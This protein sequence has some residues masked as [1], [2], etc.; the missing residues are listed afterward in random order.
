MNNDGCQYC[1]R[2]GLPLL[3]LRIAY[4]PKGAQT[5]PA[6]MGGSQVPEAFQDGGNTLRV[7]TDG[8]VY[9]LDMR[10]GGFWRCFAATPSGHFREY[11][12]DTP[13][14]S[15]PTFACSLSGHNLDASLVSIERAS[16]A[17]EVW[18]AYSRAWWTPATRRKL[19]T[20]AALRDRL[21][22]KVGAASMVKGG[23]VPTVIG[24]RVATGRDLTTI[25]PEYAIDDASFNVVDKRYATNTVDPASA[26][27]GQA[28][29]LIKRMQ[30]ISPNNAIVL[31]LPD[32]VGMA[33]DANHWRNLQAGELVNLQAETKQ[34]RS[35]LVGDLILGLEKSMVD[36][37]QSEEWA[38]RY[39][40]HV[41]MGRVRQDKNAFDTA[42]ERIEKKVL[43]ASDDWLAVV[44]HA[45]FPDAWKVY[46]PDSAYCGLQMEADFADCVFGSGATRKEQDW[47]DPWL[48]AKPDDEQH[49]VWLAFAAGDK[50]VIKYL[51]GDPSKPGETGK[52]SKGVSIG[53]HGKAIYDEFG[54]WQ[55]ARREKNLVRSAQEASGMLGM[56][57]ATQLARVATTQPKAAEQAIS[58][59]RVIASSRMDVLV[60]RYRTQISLTE[61][62]VQLHETVWGQPKA[63]LSATV[64]EARRLKIAQSIDGAFLGGRFTAERVVTLD[65]WLPEPVIDKMNQA[66]NAVIPKG[67]GAPAPRLALG[68]PAL[69]PWQG[70]V[71]YAKSLKGV[72]G[73]LFGLGA[74]LTICN[75]NWVFVQAQRALGSSA[76]TD[77]QLK[78][79]IAG[80][81]SGGMG[82]ASL[83][84][85]IFAGVV[86]GRAGRGVTT[87][88]ANRLILNSVKLKLG[89][90]LLG[91][92]MGVTEAYLF[93]GKMTTAG[94]A[95][96]TDAKN[97]Y[98]DATFFAAGAGFLSIPIAIIGAAQT[99][100]AI[101][102]T[103]AFA[104]A[105]TGAAGVLS[106]IPL[107]G[108]II[109][110][111]GAIAASVYFAYKAAKAEDTPLEIWLSRCYYRD[112]ARYA[113]TSREKFTQ[114]KPEMADFQ[115]AVYGLTVTL[116]W[117]DRIGKDRIDVE[118]IM[119]GYAGARSE[120][121]FLFD[122]RQAGS[123][124]MVID[125]KSSAFS[126]DS[127][128]KPQPAA[129]HF[130]SAASPNSI[131]LDRVVE[132]EQPTRLEVIGATAR[133]VAQVYA[134]EDYFDTARLKF[135][136]WP[137][138][139]GH[140]DLVMTPVPG[141]AN[142]QEVRD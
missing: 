21:M 8:Y 121:A 15:V 92:L 69:N 97:A 114:L 100:S 106:F 4:V 132:V 10:A 133:L 142:M 85:E 140:P 41:D 125:R 22:I 12:A 62:I 64:R 131:P 93:W 25:A 43:K 104:S 24:A 63:G 70:T 113:N 139:V 26:R 51:T 137:D 76:A 47:W 53:K 28:D 48:L 57:L 128:L 81:V 5:I 129:Q 2:L 77:P 134:N 135:E 27:V 71:N 19:K 45:N 118:V 88:V 30:A 112:E 20:D 86:K 101:G 96:D 95:G 1:N 46:D 6:G 94:A 66:A 61:T 89:G 87:S 90:A 72:S 49:P 37:G 73:G 103:G 84:T 123:P 110:A 127:D 23:A 38:D 33:K 98:L 35:R 65:L 75:I 119:P 52:A 74:V 50:D 11:P 105:I 29:D 138:P 141:G 107:A 18:A 3:P 55:A 126:Y 109:L 44:K 54:K 14:P 79:A 99:V 116:E 34:L 68:S 102:A 7:I 91:L 16:D 58:H 108:W 67:L 9:L 32:L 42:V 124:P 56:V 39:A 83:V 120:Y 31:A 122:L 82:V 111:V 36:A 117:R 130:L 40:Q 115:Q 13:P 17:T 78:E 136:Y 60:T 80:L 59:I